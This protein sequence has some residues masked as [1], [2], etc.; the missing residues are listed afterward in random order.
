MISMSLESTIADITARLRQG[1]FPNEQAI[2]QAKARQM[3]SHLNNVH[4][5]F[6][7][8]FL[9]VLRAKSFVVARLRSASGPERTRERARAAS[10]WKAG[11]AGHLGADRFCAG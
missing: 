8:D 7:I 4:L 10:A 1:R 2:S 5:T 9:S 11:L 6:R 3:G